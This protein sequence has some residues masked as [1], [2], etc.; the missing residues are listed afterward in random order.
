MLQRGGNASS[1]LIAQKRPSRKVGEI[2]VT[3][4]DFP[5]KMGGFQNW[6]YTVEGVRP[7]LV[8]KPAMILAAS[9]AGCPAASVKLGPSPHDSPDQ[10]E[11]RLPNGNIRASHHWSIGHQLG[12]Q[13]FVRSPRCG[14]KNAWSVRGKAHR[15]RSSQVH[16]GSGGR[17]AHRPIAPYSCLVGFQALFLRAS[18]WG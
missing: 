8:L 4:A 6:N 14:R 17:P 12:G 5:P 1:S 18:R 15:E 11:K 13:S 10:N 3:T 16:C 2:Q 7:S 9:S